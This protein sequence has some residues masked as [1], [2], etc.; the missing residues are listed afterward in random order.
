M[1]RRTFTL[2]ELLVVIAI[3]A[4]LA[5]MLLPSLR[6]AR[7]RAYSMQCLNSMKQFGIINASYSDSYNG[8]S[9]PVDYGWNGSNYINRWYWGS[10]AYAIK[11]LAGMPDSA[12]YDADS[13]W[14]KA[15][16]CSK[17]TLVT[18]ST[19]NP[20]LYHISQSY[21]LNA[22]A[23]SWWSKD[24]RAWRMSQLKSPSKTMHM[25]DATDWGIIIERSDYATKYGFRNYEYWANDNTY[26]AM[27]AYRH[28]K[29]ANVAFADGHAANM[30]YAVVQNNNEYWYPW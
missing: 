30:N 6:G 3:I 20:S 14:T 27:I 22:V 4:I 7:D 1:K 23:N 21:G 11:S 9:V 19:S 10:L 15:Y 17:A 29:G 16:I 5:S 25:A 8:W 28:F 24:P 26:N 12:V 13:G 18:K 2:I